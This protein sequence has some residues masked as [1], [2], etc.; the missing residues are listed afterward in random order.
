MA[1]RRYPW[2][3]CLCSPINLCLLLSAL[4]VSTANNEQTSDESTARD[5]IPSL[6][7]GVA[8]FSRPLMRQPKNLV[9][10]E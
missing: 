5:R 3:S 6:F 8:L 9:E 2:T 1:D 10:A 4:Q 7:D